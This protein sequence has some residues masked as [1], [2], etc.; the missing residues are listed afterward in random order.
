MGCCKSKGGLFGRK[1]T[2]EE[3]LNVP[4]KYKEAF[5]KNDVKE[6]TKMFTEQLTAKVKGFE[7]MQK[8][9]DELMDFKNGLLEEMKAETGAIRKRVTEQ[10]DAIKNQMGQQQEEA[11]GRMNA[12]IEESKS[13]LEGGA[14]KTGLDISS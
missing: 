10:T 14:G 7:D 13:R 1:P 5:E 8:L 4:E 12:Q 11:L 2:D 9:Q 6:L 3:L